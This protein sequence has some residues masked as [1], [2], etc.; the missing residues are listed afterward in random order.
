M[1]LD[2]F[3]LIVFTVTNIAGTIGIILQAPTFYDTATPL[4]IP[5]PTRPLGGD[6]LSDF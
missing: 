6:T 4:N 3:F 1:V 5:N 2:R